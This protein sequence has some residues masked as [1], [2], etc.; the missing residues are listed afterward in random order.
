ME[1]GV[2]FFKIL[3]AALAAYL[4]GAI[5]TALIYSRA[6]HSA[7]IR[8]LGDGNLGAR[9]IKRNFGWRAGVLVA[10]VDI[11]KG[12]LAVWLSIL[13][14]MPEFW[15]YTC[16]ALAILGHDFPVF[17]RFKGGQG[18]AV[19][20]GVF[21]GLFPVLT[22]IGAFLYAAIYFTTRSSD[23]G[24]SVGMGFLAAA[25]WLTGGSL[26]SILY[27]VLVLLFVPFKKWLDRPRREQ[28]EQN[29][30]SRPSM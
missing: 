8:T 29:A 12:A 30:G 17:A 9:N 20:T 26:A 1:N 25:Q 23:L 2:N 24:A 18:F 28:I 7:D 4:L 14:S 3:A 22:L 27:I 10:L 11:V 16:G 19:T 6:A 13:L 15:H 21:L 5:P